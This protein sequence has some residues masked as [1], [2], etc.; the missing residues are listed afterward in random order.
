MIDEAIDGEMAVEMAKKNRYDLILMDLVMPKLDGYEATRLIRTH[1][2][3]SNHSIP[4]LALTASVV[5]SEIV[6][7]QE[8]G[9]NGFIPKP[10]KAFEL[11]AIIYHALHGQTLPA[12]MN[13]TIEKA[14]SATS[15]KRIQ[16]SYLEEYA[17]GDLIRIQRF[18]ELFLTKTPEGLD[19]IKKAI[20]NQ[21]YETIRI[22]AHSLKPPFRSV[23]LIDGLETL[24][25]LESNAN[26][27]K[28]I[29]QMPE[30]MAHLS[31]L[32]KEA[33]KELK[34]G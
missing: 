17:E 25:T 10:F 7:S 6:R 30:M 16:R 13:P 26:E 14:F 8:E 9:M 2:S 5:K 15:G 11:I 21:D 34:E 23:G 18:I 20:N 4:I 22:T 27:R 1:L 28:N 19:K 32:F 31:I 24:D 29:A 12:L 3:S 33:S